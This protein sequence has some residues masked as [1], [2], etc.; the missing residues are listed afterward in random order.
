MEDNDI[1]ELYF[2]RD[3]RAIKETAEKYGKL[4][5]AIATRILGNRHEADEC[6]NDTYFGIWKAI[7]PERPSCLRAFVAKVVRNLAIGQL[8]YNMA[9]KR[10]PN[11]VIS[12]TE[13]E[14]IIPDTSG[15]DEIEDKEVG[16]RISEFLQ[17]EKEDYRNIFIRKYWFLDPISDIAE[18]FGYSESKIKSI[19]FRTRN[20]LKE[21]LTEYGI[22]CD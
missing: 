4:C 20:K 1:I 9:A 16:R 17:N 2:D 13:L 14:E 10:N 18:R 21:Y 19:L 11:A 12:L 7:P 5:T 6:V 8:K 3:E 15:F 22:S